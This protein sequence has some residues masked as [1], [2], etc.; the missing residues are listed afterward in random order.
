M[1]TFGCYE[2]LELSS[3]TKD[4]HNN[5]KINNL[6]NY[7]DKGS[8]NHFP[9]FNGP[10]NDG[11]G[12]GCTANWITWSEEIWCSVQSSGS[13]IVSNVCCCVDAAHTFFGGSEFIS[14]RFKYHIPESVLNEIYFEMTWDSN[15]SNDSEFWSGTLHS[16][17]TTYPASGCNGGSSAD[18]CYLSDL[19][20]DYCP[21]LVELTVMLRYKTSENGS[22]CV[23]NVRS[24]SFQWTGYLNCQ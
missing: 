21:G 15:T 17:G 18:C 16:G 19:L 3:N 4:K 9:K 2:D 11:P 12:S 23:C 13:G 10:E 8:F 7:S 5:S 6:Y 22:Y 14:Y 1:A 24:I 20:Y